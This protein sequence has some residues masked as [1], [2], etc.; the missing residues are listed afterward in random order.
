MWKVWRNFTRKLMKFYGS[1]FGK[2]KKILV[3]SW[4]NL[5]KFLKKIDEVLCENFGEILR[6]IRWNFEKNLERS[7]ESFG[8]ILE[9]NWWNSSENLAEYGELGQ[10]Q[11]LVKSWE[12]YSEILKKIWWNHVIV[13]YFSSCY[14]WKVKWFHSIFKK[15]SLNF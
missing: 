13:V 1:L 3:K 6:K 2:I 14:H 15:N 7:W 11:N 9:K 10:E 8:E 12:Q 4:K 5:A